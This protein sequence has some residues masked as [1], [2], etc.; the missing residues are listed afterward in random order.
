MIKITFVSGRKRNRNRPNDILSSAI[1]MG[2]VALV[3]LASKR[4]SEK[5][6][7]YY[8]GIEKMW[9]TARESGDFS[10]I[11]N[12]EPNM[13]GHFLKMV[14][15]STRRYGNRES[16][17]VYS[18]LEGT[19]GPLNALLNYAGARLRDLSM[20]LYTFPEPETFHIRKYPDGSKKVLTKKE[21]D[22]LGKDNAI[23]TYKRTGYR[24]RGKSPLVLLA[25]P[26]MPEM[27]FVDMIRAHLVELCRQCFIHNVPRS[28]AHRYIRLL[29]YKLRPF[30]DWVYTDGEY[31]RPYF[32]RYSDNELRDVVVEIRSLH[33]KRAGRRKSV[34]KI[35]D[36]AG[37]VRSIDDFKGKILKLRENT[38][39]EEELELYS[40]ILDHIDN[41]R[42]V[43][44]DMEKLIEQVLSLRSKE[45]NEWH[46]ILLS[47]LHHPQS[48][49]QVVYAGDT[50]LDECSSVLIVG[51]LP[52]SRRKGQADLVIFLRRE[53]PG[54][55]IWTPVMILE[56]KT[57]ATMEYNLYGFRT[58]NRNVE[59]YVPTLY[60][61][62]RATTDNEWN[63]IFSSAP[64]DRTVRQLNAYES[65]VL[66]EYRQAAPFDAASPESLWKGVIVLDTDQSPLEV[67]ESFHALLDDLV[68]GLITDLIDTSKATSYI[69]DS[70]DAFSAPR[71]AA[72]LLPHD[73]PVGLLE[74]ACKPQFLP[75]DD[76]F[77]DRVSDD[78]L[79]TL[80]V[81]IPSPISSGNP[82]AWISRNWH[83][84]HHIEECTQTSK[85]AEVYWI[86]LMGNY[87]TEYLI[88]QRFD[89]DSLLDN[90]KIDR[91][92]HSTLNRLLNR[93]NF[94]NLNINVEEI[95]RNNDQ[96]F[97]GLATNL[98]VIAQEENVGERI[99]V[100]DGWSE[101]R[102]M[103]PLNR[104]HLIRSLEI[105]LMDSLPT[106][107]TN[108]IWIDS[109]VEHTR[110]NRHYQRKCINPLP[111][112]SPRRKHLD[113]IIYN[114]PT[115]S[116]GFGRLLPKND[117]ERFIVQD[118]P[119]SVPPWVTKIHVPRLVDY[120][121]RFRGGQGR[122][123]TLTEEE[124]IEKELEPMYG[125]G[126]TLS[127]VRSDTS[128]QR[129]KQ[130]IE[131]ESIALSLVPST[132]RL[133]G[134]QTEDEVTESKDPPRPL[135][136]YITTATN[137]HS[138]NLCPSAPPPESPQVEREYVPADKITRR[139][140]Y[141][142]FPTE[143]SDEDD[144]SVV[145]RPPVVGFSTSNDI[146]TWRTRVLELRRLMKT[147]QFLKPKLISKGLLSCVETVESICSEGLSGK[148]DN[149][150]LLETLEIVRST[151]L[152]DPER[153]QVWET[154]RPTRLGLLELLNSKNRSVIEEISK[155]N[156]DV[157]L[158]YGNNLFLAVLAVMDTLYGTILHNN[159]V[160]LWQSVVEWELYQIGFKPQ[161]ESVKTKYDLYSLYSNLIARA[162]TLPTLSI[163]EIAISTHQS[164]QIVWTEEEDIFSAWIL[165]RT[166]KGVVAGLVDN[167]HSQ[168]LQPKWYQCISDPHIMRDK[169][170]HALTS[171]DRNAI[172]I[173]EVRNHKILW[174][175]T[176][177]EDG[178]VWI[179]HV[180]EYGTPRI[181][182][183]SV[184]WM[185]LTEVS[186]VPALYS[187]MITLPIPPTDVEGHVD[188][189]LRE[190][191]L[192]NQEVIPIT[193]EV[194]IDVKKLEYK[195]NFKAASNE[196]IL[197]TLLFKDTLKLVKTLRHPIRFGTPFE[198]STGSLVM[199]DHRDD[200][201]YTG[202]EI[203][204]G[205]RNE[206]ISLTFLKPLVH[207]SK[208]HP[209]EYDFPETC[210]DL[211]SASVGD[212]I[213]LII[214][215]ADTTF[216]CLK[217]E[218]E[219]ISEQSSLRL[220]ENLELNIYELALL[221]EC[222]QLID[223][224]TQ[225]RHNVKIDARE[226]FDLRFSRLSDYPRLQTAIAS[227]DVSDYDW[228]RES[229]T[230]QVN[231]PK[232]LKNEIVWTIVSTR[233]GKVWQNKTFDYVMDY[234]L[235]ID[236][237]INHFEEN[238]SQTIP[239]KHLSRLA[240]TIARLK[241]TLH[242]RGWEKGKPRCR[243]DLETRGGAYVAVVSRLESG[244][245]TSEI[246]SFPVDVMI[247]EE[248][249]S[250]EM[251][252]K[253]GPL[254]KFDVVNLEEFYESV[255]EA[256][257]E[258]VLEDDDVSEP[259]EET[260][261]LQV[262]SDWREEDHPYAQRFLGEALAKL[263]QLYLTKD[264]TSDALK[265]ADEA[266]IILRACDTLSSN[267]RLSLSR[268][269]VSKVDVL[270]RAKRAYDEVESLLEEARKL[271][272]SLRADI[273]V[274]EVI[275]WID[276][277]T[278][279]KEQI[280]E[281]SKT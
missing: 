184:P 215:S 6:R 108:V 43:Q 87:P 216:R 280:S 127:S 267:V 159:V 52:V 25:H 138:L 191:A 202:C 137:T 1:Y 41:G 59:D 246:A 206:V 228:T 211:M 192:M 170:R 150:S 64:D 31:G 94:V 53:V 135:V 257:P 261:L 17:R 168:W 281:K 113:E 139:W 264:K 9:Q 204:R 77:R 218:M 162:K 36:E 13:R 272:H 212:D 189:L 99:I 274:Q 265:A 181:E 97:G 88:K 171:T 198:T 155:E 104:Y 76:P 244:G 24:R 121:K 79:L 269:L 249:L 233:T 238:V 65:E 49:K 89:L 102:D 193:C 29:I 46:R 70:T 66:S 56:V 234:V 19:V 241:R 236:E 200:I 262:I 67:F 118:V 161:Q 11:Q 74:E 242:D 188:N 196:K 156:P 247:D 226:L 144:D 112:D 207:R 146:D 133:R 40:T 214:H 182:N 253:W 12:T 268:A 203:K 251:E 93:I 81:P 243:V 91:S 194:S 58:K 51:E 140:F 279:Q 166:E 38:N 125:R 44:R 177:G 45:G 14:W 33:G 28:E 210:D 75:S 119:A 256:S 169:A 259:V 151:L 109:G 255:S 227:L 22:L 101:F 116:R 122:K 258:E 126:V 190:V 153:R 254:S 237:V 4:T 123:P 197:E 221:T 8:N 86:D 60:A 172:V 231:Y 224:K 245:G 80:Y 213:T 30:L 34:T 271:V 165:F 239:L 37:E 15:I 68:M 136:A 128:R 130:L 260:E 248:I 85:D 143:G 95:L 266:I 277:L 223:T 208:F 90:R 129:K 83:L 131:L 273:S 145:I 71:V 219:E 21:D 72:I 84:L 229:W 107:H 176:E 240:E 23:K 235:S 164:G 173:T 124:V 42:I 82:A 5:T 278:K 270:V 174:M 27:D 92:K 55:I 225:T 152:E 61:W 7:K 232:H 183:M 18:W 180:F 185:R 132:L 10:V 141:E 160:P 120:S 16:K 275:E 157:F 163:P 142:R 158:L 201:E 26:T 3:R 175:Q 32:N 252:G 100:I 179:P 178:P 2:L 20:T 148:F 105:R 73:G 111:F 263:A 78:R 154:V 48:L 134:D 63:E 106:S 209:D 205:K 50:M 98:G 220:L 147:T 35:L 39:D 222:E 115:S 199:W 195:L 167:L 57:K 217:V 187:E 54:R 276:R 110:M 149:G 186:Q 47:D 96:G 103:V 250:H 69:L 117:N 114:I 230:L 62:K